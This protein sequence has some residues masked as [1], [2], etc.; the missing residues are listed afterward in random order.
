M[1]SAALNRMA[2]QKPHFHTYDWRL[3]IRAIDIEEAVGFEPTDRVS[4]I[5]G[6]ANRCVKPLCHASRLMVIGHIPIFSTAVE[7]HWP[8]A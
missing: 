2:I 6:L 7:Y 1:V 3:P 5:Y 8:S 4:S